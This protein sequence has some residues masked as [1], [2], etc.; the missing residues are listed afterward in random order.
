MSI[1][2]SALLLIVNIFLVLLPVLH[3]YPSIS[4]L[5]LSDMCNWIPEKPL[6]DGFQPVEYIHTYIPKRPKAQRKWRRRRSGGT[7]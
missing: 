3:R 7:G 4:F 6:V 2:C 5:L 1:I